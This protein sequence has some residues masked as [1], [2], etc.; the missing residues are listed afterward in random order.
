[1]KTLYIVCN[2][3]AAGDMLMAALL[4][5]IEDKEQVLKQLNSLLP[6][7]VTVALEP[8][9]KCGV[10]GSHIRVTVDGI[11]EGVCHHGHHDH[12][13]VH[14]EHHHHHSGIAEIYKLI[15]AMEVAEKV[16]NNLSGYISRLEDETTFK[17]F[18][19]VTETI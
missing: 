3:G 2:M 13:H 1:M 10:T 11:E 17:E 18:K 14:A 12:E 15:E 9:E 4:E 5:L 16:K 19:N 7:K 8:S 6:E